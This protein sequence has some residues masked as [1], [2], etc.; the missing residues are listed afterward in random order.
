MES[1]N[2]VEVCKKCYKK[3]SQGGSCYHDGEWHSTYGKCGVACAA[4]LALRLSVGK[5]HWSCCFS[6]FQ[7]DEE[8]K[9]AIHKYSSILVDRQISSVIETL[10]IDRI[11][12][13]FEI[14]AKSDDFQDIET[15][16]KANLNNQ[17][18]DY[19]EKR[20]KL[21]LNPISFHLKSAIS[22]TNIPLKM[23][24]QN[25]KEEMISSD[26]T[27]HETKE[28]YSFHGTD[29]KNLISI[30]NHGLLKVGHHKN[31]SESTDPG[32][33]GDPKQGVYVGKYADY[34][35]KYSNGLIP[36]KEGESAKLIVFKTLPGKSFHIPY[37]T[38]SADPTPGY[39]S[40][41]SPNFMEWYLFDEAQCHPIYIIELEAF[42]NN[43]VFSDDGK[44]SGPRSAL[45]R[46]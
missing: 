14:E 39:D 29:P 2:Y 3:R 18:E 8:C 40:H 34:S 12:H 6:L 9:S 13:F 35:L 33:F 15:I 24:F 10:N 1:L 30:C 37:I 28:R 21:G 36:L 44:C 31:P 45:T 26:R 27:K 41:S 46:S 42:V 23:R 17:I 7:T 43:R 4:S 5:K 20:I 16:V 32:W 22:V 19:V 25:K 11:A 38:P